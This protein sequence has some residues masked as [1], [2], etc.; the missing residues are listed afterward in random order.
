MQDESRPGADTPHPAD[1][2]KS[3]ARSTSSVTNRATSRWNGNSKIGRRCRDLYRSYSRQ[4]GNPTEPAAQAALVALVE[5]I[6]LAELARTACLVAGGMSSLNLALVIRCE[7]LANRTLKRLKLDK[8]AKSPSQ[9]KSFV[10]KLEE[11]EAARLA[12]E[13]TVIEQA[14]GDAA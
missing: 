11:R 7:N 8:P 6:T 10:E 14:D 4:A 9:R 13:A 3:S 5:Q 2:A 1:V 12:V